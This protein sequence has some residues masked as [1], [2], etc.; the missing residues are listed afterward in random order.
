MP[1][2]RR[3]DTNA[4]GSVTWLILGLH[5]THVLTDL[6]DTLVLAVLMFTRHADNPRRFGD[7]E[8]NVMYW[9]FVVL[10]WLP[11]YALPLLGAAAV[12]GWARHA[13]LLAAPAAWAVSVQASQLLPHVDCA[14][15]GAWTAATAAL[16]LAVALGAAGLSLGGLS[17]GRQLAGTG[18]FLAGLAGLVAL[19]LGFALLLQTAAALMLDP[20]AR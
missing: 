15:Q 6:V 9:N 19:T 8:D 4:Y 1:S 2:I 12:S 11:L 20:C 17:F 5:T 16:A 18:R 13:G 10:T 14:G 7:V 3:W